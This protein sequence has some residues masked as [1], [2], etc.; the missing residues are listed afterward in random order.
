MITP[1]EIRKKAERIYNR[2]FLAAHLKGENFF[3][4]EIPGDKGKSTDP[5]VKGLSEFE[6]LME[7]EKSKTGFGYTVRMKTV[8]THKRGMQ[9]G[10]DQILF[11]TE[12]DFL[13]FIEKD[14]E[15]KAFAE[16][17]A[18]IRSRIPELEEWL[19]ANPKPVI[20][21]AGR[22]DGLLKVCRYFMEHPRPG[23]YIR[24]LP[25]EV[26]TKF[27]EENK[28][29][30]SNLLDVLLS[31]D[32]VDSNCKKKDFVG[33]YGLR[34]KEDRVWFRILDPGAA[35]DLPASLSDLSL[36]LSEFA[37][38]NLPCG[39]VFITENE[40]TFLAFPAVRS[41]IVIFGGG[42]KALNL[43]HAKWLKDKDILYWGDID[44][45][46]FDILSKLRGWFPQ[47][48]SLLMDRE[49][50][51]VF[52][53]F[54]VS[55]KESAIPKAPNLT[56]EEK[57]MFQILVDHPEKNRLEQERIPQAVVAAELKK[58]AAG[59]DGPDCIGFRNIK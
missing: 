2:W 41:S 58:R 35:P 43:R 14:P 19:I 46:G 26:H 42:Y 13:R 55:A 52:K 32:A 49:T 4:L 34:C 9:T 31:P 27:I 3:P 47:V 17:A 50:F 21:N 54:A 40:M 33:R 28:G 29:I 37:R 7:E 6:R 51:C 10:P 20:A 23:L 44:L 45:P 22:W 56:A 18:L 48:K 38:L 25:V 39:Q 36:S 16:D 8:N 57:A 5:Y 59:G 30:L 15:F 53:G 12:A 1:K 11:E 24:E